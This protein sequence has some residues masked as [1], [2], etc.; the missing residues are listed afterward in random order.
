[1]LLRLAVEFV[2]FFRAQS[3]FKG[4]VGVSVQEVIELIA[5]G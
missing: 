4:V 3:A 2:S 5:D 1:M